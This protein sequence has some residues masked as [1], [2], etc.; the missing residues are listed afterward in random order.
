MKKKKQIE[1]N[2][3]TDSV[4]YSGSVK[5]KFCRN[6]KVLKTTIIKNMGTKLLFNSIASILAGYYRTAQVPRFIAVGSKGGQTAIDSTNLNEEI[7]RIYI[8]DMRWSE[9]RETNPD[10]SNSE[11]KGSR[12]T[13]IATIPYASINGIQIREFGL[14]ADENTNSMLARI[15]IDEGIQLDEGMSFTIEWTILVQNSTLAN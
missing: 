4:S 13:F 5:L 11:Y 6:N 10:N 1:E 3:I 2:K 7:T 8:Q 12:A 15:S 9:Y 14:F